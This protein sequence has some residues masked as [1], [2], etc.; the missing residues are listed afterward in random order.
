[1]LQAFYQVHLFINIPLSPSVPALKVLL[2]SCN[3]RGHRKSLRRPMTV[4]VYRPLVCVRHYSSWPSSHICPTLT[5][6]LF[7]ETSFIILSLGDL[8]TLLCKFFNSFSWFKHCMKFIKTM[9]LLY[10]KGK[11]ILACLLL[12]GWRPAIPILSRSVLS[13]LLLARSSMYLIT[14]DQS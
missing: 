13:F 12:A 5:I 6:V 8:K 4:W 3:L 9:Q 14:H 7:P 10:S 2:L 11:R 1:M